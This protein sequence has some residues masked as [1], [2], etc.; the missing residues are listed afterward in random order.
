M[1]NQHGAWA[2]FPFYGIEFPDT[3]KRMIL[4]GKVGE[5]KFFRLL[6]TN[7]KCFEVAFFYRSIQRFAW[8][9]PKVVFPMESRDNVAFRFTDSGPSLIIYGLIVLKDG[10]IELDGETWLIPEDFPNYRNLNE[11]LAIR[12]EASRAEREDWVSKLNLT[13]IQLGGLVQ[14]LIEEEKSLSFLLENFEENRSLSRDVLRA[15]RSLILSGSRNLTPL[16]HVVASS[17]AVPLDI[18]VDAAS[19]KRIVHEKTVTIG[20]VD[21]LFSP[22]SWHFLTEEKLG[23]VLVDFDAYLHA[24]VFV[25]DSRSGGAG[26][27]NKTLND[28]LREFAD[29]DAA[30]HDKDIG[31]FHSFLVNSSWEIS[32]VES[33]AAKLGESVLSLVRKV[34]SQFSN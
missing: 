5:D 7:E 10:Q 20:G 24:K 25:D 14:N 9:I 29:K 1:V 17:Y 4:D 18:Y 19:A 11:S 27:R 31:D 13:K 6:V 33:I 16:L 2:V 28:F 12:S 32:L 23:Y 34:I 21:A 8:Y 26:A 30:H 3:E 22:L 15:L